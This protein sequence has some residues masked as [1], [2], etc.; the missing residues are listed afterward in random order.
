M[1]RQPRFEPEVPK[2][3]FL[4]NKRSYL[5]ETEGLVEGVSTQGSGIVISKTPI[6]SSQ[7]ATTPESAPSFANTMMYRIILFQI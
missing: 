5:L 6:S 1:P 4:R 3:G 2:M 7:S